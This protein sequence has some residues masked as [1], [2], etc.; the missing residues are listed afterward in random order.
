[1]KKSTALIAVVVLV[2]VFVYYRY[3]AKILQVNKGE[4]E[5]PITDVLP[6]GSK[7]VSAVAKYMATEDKE[8]E[9]R[10][11]LTV[12]KGGVITEV[13]TLDAKTNEVPEKKKE[14]NQQVSVMIVGKKLSELSSIDNVAKSSLTTKA[15][16]SVV[17]Q[18][19]AQL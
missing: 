1:M 9:L 7:K 12:D 18:L 4:N 5:V 15:F 17:D 14:F 8:D 10:F 11:V 3:T 2:S 16:N 19:K 6:V 13:A